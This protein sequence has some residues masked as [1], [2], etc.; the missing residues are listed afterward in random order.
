LPGFRVKKSERVVMKILDQLIQAVETEARPESVL[1]GPYLA[2]VVIK[3]PAAKA[4]RCGMATVF[5][6]HEP[7]RE[8]IDEPGL[9]EERPVK[10]L[11]RLARSKRPLEA[12]VGMATINACL[13]VD[14]SRFSD[15]N[16]FEILAEKC[17]DKNLTLIGHFPFADKLKSACKNCWTL[18]LNPRK[19]DLPANAA[20]QV[21]PN[22]QIIGITASAFLNHTIERL[23]E[24]SRGKYVMV[25]GPTSPLSTILFEYGV[26]AI[27]G[28]WVNDTTAAIR[29]ISQGAT[30]RMLKGVRKVVMQK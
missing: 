15:I 11:C 19:G 25:I 16:A 28:A 30:Y 26:S 21:I 14:T 1:I 2:A 7:A 8:P 20:I 18:E 5:A 22:S 13:P 10:D 3:G 27:A 29:T 9:L 23:L 24:L 6:E 4:K 12:S 17:R